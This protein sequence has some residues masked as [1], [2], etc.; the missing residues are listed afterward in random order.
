MLGRAMDQMRGGPE[1][2]AGLLLVLAVVAGATDASAAKPTIGQVDADL[3]PGG[4]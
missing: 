3:T 1:S 2:L 4:R